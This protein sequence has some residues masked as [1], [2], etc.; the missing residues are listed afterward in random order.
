MWRR[1]RQPGTREIRALACLVASSLLAPALALAQPIAARRAAAALARDYIGPYLQEH[2]QVS[3]RYAA[4]RKFLVEDRGV[5][6][7][8]LEAGQTIA[9]LV[10]S[11]AGA[12]LGVLKPTVGN[13]RARSEV[14][15]FRLGLLLGVP[16][17]V[18][19]AS[20]WGLPA[21]RLPALRNLLASARFE[22]PKER[23]RVALLR[24]IQTRMQAGASLPVAVKSWRPAVTYWMSAGHLGTDGFD[25][26]S[27]L[28]PHLL[29]AGPQ[30]APD[31]FEIL[32]GS[33]WT[34]PLGRYRGWGARD[35]LAS[36]LGAIMLLD[37]L[38][39]DGDRFPG[40]NL[41]V[42][43]RTG[44]VRT[45]EPPD[46]SVAGA[47]AYGLYDLGEVSFLALDNGSG[48][49][50]V[51]IGSSRGLRT[52]ERHVSRLDRGLA[53]RLRALH[54]FLAGRAAR[55]RE[56]HDPAVL[57]AFLGLGGP[58]HPYWPLFCKLVARV[59]ARLDRLAEKYPKRMA[60]FRRSLQPSYPPL[61]RL[62][63]R[64]PQPRR[65]P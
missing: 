65:Q 11:S 13:T 54:E 5:P 25:P 23:A 30:P 55:F 10:R 48:L 17:L 39:S 7:L 14:F 8:I 37:A 59:V 62:T 12:E 47:R 18:T 42:R 40:G 4:L 9:F 32:Q 22:G 38:A 61:A 45:V 35:L 24:Q 64:S 16:Y 44:R 26:S 41:H 6:E 58:D 21:R 52:W 34:P 19:H 1:G 46:P 31:R 57:A 33:R 15:H 63:P 56:F 2:P 20:S 60:F 28:A 3:A 51:P 27:P 36:E 49:G 50:R 43:A 53:T 29:A